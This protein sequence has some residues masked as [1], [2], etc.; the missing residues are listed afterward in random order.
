MPGLEETALRALET[1]PVRGFPIHECISRG[2]GR[3]LAAEPGLVL[4]E[5]LPG[6]LQIFARDGER[7]ARVTAG[8]YRPRLLTLFGPCS[9]EPL[10]RRLGL[11]CETPYHLAIYQEAIPLQTDG[12]DVRTLGPDFSSQLRRRYSHPEFY[13]VGQFEAMLSEG[14]ILGG[15]E[16]GELVGFV[17]VHPEGSIGLLEVFEGHRRQ[18]W[19]TQLE[20]EMINRHLERGWIPWGQ[21]FEGNEASLALQRRLSM[22]VTPAWALPLAPGKP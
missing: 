10:E 17:G 21:V 1:D 15:F 18:G 14:R 2:I 12:R 19:A 6:E 8:T 22:L 11:V 3:V 9:R 4:H 20:S 7:A 16:G 5:I 13:S